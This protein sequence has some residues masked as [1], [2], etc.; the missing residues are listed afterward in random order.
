MVN[1]VNELLNE[2][3]KIQL[4][5]KFY[6]DDV[7]FSN[8]FLDEFISEVLEKEFYFWSTEVE[9]DK[10][11]EFWSYFSGDKIDNEDYKI[12]RKFF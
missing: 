6:F 1:K 11:A 2:H 8:I 10:Y 9:G 12:I 3:E 5:L 7:N 4:E